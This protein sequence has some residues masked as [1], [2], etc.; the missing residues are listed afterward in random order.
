MSMR[1][2]VVCPDCGYDGAVSVD[3]NYLID[4]YPIYCPECDYCFVPRVCS[5]CKWVKFQKETGEYVCCGV[6]AESIVKGNQD[7]CDCWE[8]SGEYE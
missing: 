3:D 6:M 5:M 2:G 1:I 4:P 8:C 7:G